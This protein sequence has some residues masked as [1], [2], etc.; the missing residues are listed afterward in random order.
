MSNPVVIV[1]ARRTAIGN[2]GGS[3]Q[4]FSA[5]Q[6]GAHLIRGLIAETGLEPARVS[7]VILGQ[8][9][10]AGCGQN[11]ARIAALQGGLP[12]SV[13]ATTVNQVCGSGLKALELAFNALHA[14]PDAIIL[15]GGQESMSQSPY[16]DKSSRWGAKMGHQ[17][18]VDSMIQ[19][20]LWDAFHDYHMG[21]TAENLANRYQISRAEQDAFA[22]NSQHKCRDALATGRFDAEILP[23]P[24]PQKKGEPLLFKTDEYPRPDTD[25]ATLAKLKPCFSKDGSVTA[26][27]SSGVNDGAALM[28]LMRA[29]RATELGLTALATVRGFANV[30]CD[31]ATMGLGPAFAVPE[32]LRRQGLKLADIDLFELNEAFAAQS[33]AVIKELGA[34]PARVNVNGGALALGHPIGASGAR[35][36]VSLLHEMH[37]RGSRL[38]VASL[39]VG[40]GMGIAMLLE[41]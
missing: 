13:P 4:S 2:F 35:I 39:C 10:T 21:T 31:P 30:G 41:A 29:S 26:G 17:Q 7:E 33:L 14:D 38:G 37:R 15:T 34:D 5:A 6:L 27:S 11:P 9:L 19:D 1:A 40:G 12:Q 22:L 25:A 20:G 32:L 8:V 18:L 36:A 16:L 24:I 28:M 3:L 23:F